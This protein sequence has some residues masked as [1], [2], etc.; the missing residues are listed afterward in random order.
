MPTDPA[1]N[2][3]SV[4]L[5]LRPDRGGMIGKRLVTILAGVINAATGHADRDDI[6]LGVVVCTTRCRVYIDSSNFGPQD[7]HSFMKA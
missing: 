7:S 5:L 3:T 6:A 4:P 1:E 2:R